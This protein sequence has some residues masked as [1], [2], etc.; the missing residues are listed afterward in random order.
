G[1]FVAET[2][3]G[4][5]GGIGSIGSNA[6]NNRFPPDW[7]MINPWAAFESP[8]EL[9]L[10]QFTQPSERPNTP[11]PWASTSNPLKSSRLRLSV[12]ATV[13]P[14]QIAPICTGSLDVVSIVAQ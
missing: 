2:A 13:P 14:L 4:L 7:R 6:A 11:R 12:Q 10:V 9:L 1:P 5:A 3:W 8:I